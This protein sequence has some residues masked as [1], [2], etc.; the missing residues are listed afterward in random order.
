[1]GSKKYKI[2][3]AILIVLFLVLATST[4]IT[5]CKST[6][7]VTSSTAFPENCTILGRVTIKTDSEK[8]GYFI[9]LEEAKRKFPGTDDVVNIIV[10]VER[11]NYF[12][13]YKTQYKMSGIAI[14]FNK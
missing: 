7:P 1:M 4:L 8:S 13:F 12:I 6:G 5:S 3:F 2:V 11:T 10:D 14:R 9:L